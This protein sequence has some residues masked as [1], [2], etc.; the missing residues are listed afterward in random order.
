[1]KDPHDED[2]INKLPDT[3]KLVPSNVRFGSA[4]TPLAEPSDVNTR[5]SA[6]PVIETEVPDVPD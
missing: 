1:M 2:T 5:L 6:A 3:R 4:T